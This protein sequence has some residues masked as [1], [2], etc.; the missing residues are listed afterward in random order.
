MSTSKAVILITGASS[1]IG[2]EVA[3][4]LAA[5]GH[6]LYITAR[7]AEEPQT[8]VEAFPDEK[9]VPLAGDLTDR[10]FR[11]TLVPTVVDAEARLDV[12]INNAGFGHLDTIEA[13]EDD[14]I[15]RMIELNVTALIELTRDAVK[16]MKKQGSGRIL[17]V[18]SVV[19]FVTLPYNSVYNATKHGVNGFTETIRHELRGTNI[20]ASAINP[21]SVDT[22]FGDVALGQKLPKA[23]RGDPP[24]AIAKSIVRQLYKDRRWLFPSFSARILYWTFCWLPWLLR[25]ILATVARKMVLKMITEAKTSPKELT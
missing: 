24:E 8:L 19:G 17:N 23:F 15:R 14:L 11:A 4:L 16:V 12:I 13:H 9:I 20:T 25:L 5:Q 2:R 22:E 21:G 10:E 18:S 1:G 6:T 7:R 3:K